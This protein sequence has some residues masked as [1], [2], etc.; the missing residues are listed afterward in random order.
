MTLTLLEKQKAFSRCVSKFINDLALRGYSVTLGEAYRPP[1]V[2]NIYASENKGI[3]N[4]N[5]IIRLAIDLNLFLDKK[6]LQTVEELTIPGALWK[7]Y[8]TDTIECAWGGDFKPNPDSDHYSFLH[9]KI[10]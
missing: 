7:S 9:G 1:A 2:A 10:R 6:W 5:H 4:S 8:S 3:A